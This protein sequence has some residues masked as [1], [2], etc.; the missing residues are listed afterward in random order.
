MIV[1]K[2]KYFHCKPVIYH[3]CIVLEGAVM[4]K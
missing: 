4:A 2:F 1:L 3:L